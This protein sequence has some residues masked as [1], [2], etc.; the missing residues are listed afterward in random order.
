MNT[1]KES[2]SRSHVIRLAELKP[3]AVSPA[4]I[5]VPRY[6]RQR[7]SVIGRAEQRQAG[8]PGSAVTANV[9]FGYL[10]CAGGKGN[11]SHKHPNWEIFIPMSGRWKMT[12]EGGPLDAGTHV[13]ELGP[14]D[15][16]VI[17]GET[18]HEAQNTSD[19]E[20]ILMS[21]N[22][23]VKAANYTVHPSVV[24]EIRR[25]SPE[26]AAAAERALDIATRS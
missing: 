24:E 2:W 3:L 21:L 8:E 15:L 23:G 6:E 16:I 18:F 12:L 7:Y 26:A 11:C 14:W 22:P 1:P 25:F 5:V 9:N 20:A 10:R 17:P 13:L 19:S 4:D